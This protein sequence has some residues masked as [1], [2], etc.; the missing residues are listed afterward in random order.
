MVMSF[1]VKFVTTDRNLYLLLIKQGSKDTQSI[2]LQL[3]VPV[4]TLY[5]TKAGEVVIV[6]CGIE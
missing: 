6:Q 1:L 5:T 3:H 4:T 2:V